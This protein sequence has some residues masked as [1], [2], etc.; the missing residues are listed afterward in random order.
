MVLCEFIIGWNNVLDET[1]HE[2]ISI[3]HSE[4]MPK[5][6]TIA[7]QRCSVWCLFLRLEF[8]LKK[9]REKK[10]NSILKKILTP[11]LH[12]RLY[13]PIGISIAFVISIMVG[14]P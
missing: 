7:V 8:I 9:K 4:N 14:K 6:V 10:M 2:N 3:H 13:F 12:N 5:G 1:N 11:N